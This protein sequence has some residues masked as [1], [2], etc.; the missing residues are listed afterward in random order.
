MEIV[1][2]D[3]MSVVLSTHLIADLERVCDHLVVIAASRVQLAGEATDLLATHCRLSGPRRDP[4]TLPSGQVVIKES[5]TDKQ[6]T[7]LVRSVQAVLDPSW[8][9]KPVTL[10]DLVLAYM[11]NQHRPARAHRPDLEIVR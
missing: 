4:S 8:K 1:A 10:D 3:G 5:H 2:Q 6:T 11:S 7:L 9:V